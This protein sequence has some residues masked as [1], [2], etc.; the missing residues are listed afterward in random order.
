MNYYLH[1]AGFI[2]RCH[3]CAGSH[4][5]THS[6]TGFDLS[7]PGLIIVQTNINSGVVIVY[8]FEAEKTPAFL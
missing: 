6:L 7:P 5:V 4:Y 1:H 3:M 8:C 2:L